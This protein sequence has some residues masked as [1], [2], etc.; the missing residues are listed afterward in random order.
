MVGQLR[1]TVALGTDVF[2][3]LQRMDN[4]LETLPVKK[5]SCHDKLEELQNQLETAKVEVERPFPREDELR[6]KTARLEELNA[7][8]NM[9]EK[10]DD[11]EKEAAEK[12]NNQEQE[13]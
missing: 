12:Q 11:D 9:D 5:N 1:H 3:N 10:G 6:Q 4:A 8:L 2:G 7:L 13:R